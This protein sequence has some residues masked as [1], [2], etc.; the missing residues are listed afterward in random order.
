MTNIEL[1]RKHF[2]KEYSNQ[3]KLIAEIDE[4]ITLHATTWV[5]IIFVDPEKRKDVLNVNPELFSFADILAK[6]IGYSGVIVGSMTSVLELYISE[7]KESNWYEPGLYGT[8]GISSSSGN[9]GIGNQGYSGLTYVGTTTN[10]C[11]EI[12]LE[13]TIQTTSA[14][15]YE[16]P[17]ITKNNVK[18][19]NKFLSKIRK[20]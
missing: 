14:Q 1:F 5:K 7:G 15:M 6:S 4:H 2:K 11:G 12:P 18:W 16:P 17:N 10:T 20:H 9:I 13:Y 19:Y 8:F 3:E